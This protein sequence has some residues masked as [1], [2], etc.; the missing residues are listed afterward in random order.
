VPAADMAELLNVDTAGWLAEIPA[1]RA[2]FAKFGD[3]LPVG[4]TDELDALEIRLKT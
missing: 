3:R 2:H 1:I 4:L